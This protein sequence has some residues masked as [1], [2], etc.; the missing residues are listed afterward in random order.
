MCAVFVREGRDDF[1]VFDCDA[2]ATTLVIDTGPDHWL[3]LG[4]IP[5]NIDVTITG[6]T[7]AAPSPAEPSQQPDAASSKPPTTPA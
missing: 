2:G 6:Q 4:H 7:C 3:D 5:D 1:V